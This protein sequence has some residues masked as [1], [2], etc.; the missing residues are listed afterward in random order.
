MFVSTL[1][2]VCL[3]YLLS[4][5]FFFFQAEDGIRDLIVTGVQTC[6]LPIWMTRHVEGWR[7]RHAAL[8]R[9]RQS[10]PS[11]E[12]HGFY[13]RCPD[14]RARRDH[15]SAFQEHPCAVVVRDGG[16]ESD[17]HVLA[18]QRLGRGFPQAGGHGGEHPV[19]GPR[20]PPA[21]VP[22]RV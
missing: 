6:A 2:C 11:G 19:G 7:H 13:A 4:F 9:R 18:P 1:V 3:A 15:L 5:F 12:G 10:E 20:E 21:D 16:P 8:L 17:L 22:D 14:E